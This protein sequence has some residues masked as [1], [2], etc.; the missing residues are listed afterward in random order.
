M[1]L[2]EKQN[3]V[4][5]YESLYQKEK[6]ERKKMERIVKSLA[7]AQA[8]QMGQV[9]RSRQ[10]DYRQNSAVS[11]SSSP[12]PFNVTNTKLTQNIKSE[13]LSSKLQSSKSNRIIYSTKQNND[14]LGQFCQINNQIAPR[15]QPRQPYQKTVSK[16]TLGQN[17]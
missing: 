17:P 1:Q 10:K 15:P 7:M 4:L 11:C 5:H 13:A 9:Q 6:K 16:L 8:L 3:K 14:S 2:K 12:S